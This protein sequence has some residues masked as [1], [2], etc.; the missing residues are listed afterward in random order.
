MSGPVPVHPIEE[1]S[2]RILAQQVDLSRF[3]P[4]VAAVIARVVHA[5]AEPAGRFADRSR[6]RRQSRGVAAPGARR[7]SVLCDV[8]MVR[9]GISGAVTWPTYAA[10]PSAGEYPAAAPPAMA[11][12]RPSA[13]PTEPWS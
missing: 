8:E 6:G 12:A 11:S 9:A 4:D 1:E 13:L 10:T 3:A 7:A 2:Y 5:M